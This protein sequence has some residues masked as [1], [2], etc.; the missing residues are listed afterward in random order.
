MSERVITKSPFKIV[1]LRILSR[2]TRIKY[3]DIYNDVTNRYNGLSDNEKTRVANALYEELHDVFE[4]FGFEMKLTRIKK[5]K[6]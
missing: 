1:S 6:V 5:E 3:M 4:Y 2:V